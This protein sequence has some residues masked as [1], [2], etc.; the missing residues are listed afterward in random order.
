MKYIKFLGWRGR[1][2]QRPGT[3]LRWKTCRKK[4]WRKT[5]TKM[6]WKPCGELWC[7]NK[8]KVWEI[9][10]QPSSILNEH[11]GLKGKWP[12]GCYVLLL[13]YKISYH[14]D[15]CETRTPVDIVVPRH[16]TIVAWIAC[17]LFV[18]LYVNFAFHSF[19][20]F[21][22]GSFVFWLLVVFVCFLHLFVALVC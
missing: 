19:V 13:V 9:V 1:R 14:P 5:C 10:L 7:D 8:Q 15:A 17:W 6:W 21:L 3:K 20:P 16:V 4:L 22:V 18:F 12:P 2:Q 11:V